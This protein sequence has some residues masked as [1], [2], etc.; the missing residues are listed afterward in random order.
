VAN[1]TGEAREAP[2]RPSFDRRIKLE[3][4]GSRITSDAGL[5]AYRELDD[6]FGLA[7]IAIGLAEIAIAKL[8]DDRRG[9]NVRHKLGGLFRQAVFGRVAGYEEDRAV[10]AHDLAR[11]TR[12]DRRLDRA[13]RPLR[14]LPT[15]GGRGAARRV[16][17]D[18]APDRPPARTARGG[19]VKRR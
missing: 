16:R 1:A 3:F 5:L 15:G 10:V 6:A 14:G 7:E 19:D 4:H 11:E 13:P 9:K 18:P 17:R 12:E 2:L 8:L